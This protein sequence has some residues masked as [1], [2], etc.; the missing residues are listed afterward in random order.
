MI[1]KT[2]AYNRH[3]KKVRVFIPE[4]DPEPE[5]EVGMEVMTPE[6]VATITRIEGERI[7]TGTSTLSWWHHTK[8]TPW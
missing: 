5:L 7:F 1:M 8:V 4:N 2:T 6:G 3:G